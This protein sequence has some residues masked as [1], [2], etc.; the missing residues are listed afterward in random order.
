[1]QVRLGKKFNPCYRSV[2]CGEKMAILIRK[3][4]KIDLYISKLPDKS[5]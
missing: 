3:F 4:N 5:I 2:S 1:M